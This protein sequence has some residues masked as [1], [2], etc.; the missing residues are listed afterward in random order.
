MHKAE[1][2]KFRCRE[3]TVMLPGRTWRHIYDQHP[4]PIDWLAVDNAASW[5][6]LQSHL[7]AKRSCK[8][9]GDPPREQAA[10]VSRN[11]TEP[12]LVGLS[13]RP[14]DRLCKG[15]E[16]GR[17]PP[18]HRPRW[19]LQCPLW[20]PGGLRDRSSPARKAE[21]G[22]LHLPIGSK[23]SSVSAHKALKPCV[24]RTS[25]AL[26]NLRPNPPTTPP[27]CSGESGIASHTCQP[28]RGSRNDSR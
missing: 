19:T 12:G 7:A 17:D 14:E 3:S 13:P 26:P 25:L 18:G 9:E 23:P 11:W 20:P 27:P 5:S 21:S 28:G 10:G 4:V 15:A 8:T 1:T 24:H 6:P 2:L 16:V 22:N